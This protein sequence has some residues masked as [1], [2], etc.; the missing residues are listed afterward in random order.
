MS[1]DE[2]MSGPFRRLSASVLALL[3]IRLELL[4]LEVQEEKDRLVHML[5]WAVVSAFLGCFALVFLA[6]FAT[7]ALWD[8]H[9]LL[10]LGLFSGLFVVLALWGVREL[11]R[12]ARAGTTLFQGS[13]GELRRDSAAL[14]PERAP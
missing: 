13:L 10:V 3:R 5:V 2:V 1:P 7:V 4:A 8:T 12:L 6:V 9:R 11:R 14:D